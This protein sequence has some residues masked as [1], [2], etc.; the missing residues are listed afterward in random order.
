MIDKSVG[1]DLGTTYSLVSVVE[2]GRPKLIPIQGK[3]SIPSVVTYVK[4]GSCLVGES[5]ISMNPSNTFSSIKR[6]MGKSVKDASS[7]DSFKQFSN[8]IVKRNM[9]ESSPC[10]LKC[11][12][13]NSNLSPEE[14]SSEILRFLLTNAKTYLKALHK[15]DEVN[16]TKAVITV[17]AYFDAK[18]RIATEK[19]G[20]LAGLSKVKILKEPEAAALAYGLTQNKPQIV[21]VFDLG[22]GTFDVSVLEVG[23]GF[24]EVIATSGDSNLGGDDFDNIIQNYLMDQLALQLQLSDIRIESVKSDIIVQNKLK[25]A[26][27]NAKINLSRNQSVNIYLPN[28]IENNFDLNCTLT[29]KKFDSLSKNLINRLLR[30]L[31]EVSLMAGINLP[32]ESGQLVKGE[33]N[34]ELRRLQKEYKDPSLSLFPTGQT[35]DEVILVGGATRMP[36]I[37]KLVKVITGIDPKRT[38]NPDEAV[39]LGAG[40]LAGILDGD[41]KNMQVMSS[42]QSAMYRTFFEE[43]QKGSLPS[44]FGQLNTNNSK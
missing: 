27:I 9:I 28:L 17:P 8:K 6:L 12:N 15:V 42:L 18:Q 13:V 38:V 3:T 19:A 20:L 44:L 36:S 4:N 11:N 32:G 31:R 7:I 23:N 29:R 43:Q 14:I 37:I 41:I 26:A 10:L 21:L 40:I 30:P 33:S 39:C 34:K 16:I 25:N 35:L 24:V 1:I 2:N 5:A 22:G